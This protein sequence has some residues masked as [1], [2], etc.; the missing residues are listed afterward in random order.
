MK[1]SSPKPGKWTHLGALTFSG[2]FDMQ[3]STSDGST[4][5]IQV[6]RKYLCSSALSDQLGVGVGM[7]KGDNAKAKGKLEQEIK[8][9]NIP[10]RWLTRPQTPFGYSD[11]FVDA[12][13]LLAVLF[14]G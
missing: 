5:W 12:G 10:I 8:Y 6:S 2:L 1:S 9:S 14:N 13:R 3:S 4:C 7:K 11:V